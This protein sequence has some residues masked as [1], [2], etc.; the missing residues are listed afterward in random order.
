MQDFLRQE[1]VIGDYLVFGHG[2]MT[3]HLGVVKNVGKKMFSIQ[4]QTG[5]GKRINKY[6]EGVLKITPEQAFWR[7]LTS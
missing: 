1:V 4:S 7:V 6:P 5:S 2:L 3:L